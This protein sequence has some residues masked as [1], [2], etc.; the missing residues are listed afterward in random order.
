MADCSV[1]RTAPLTVNGWYRS[2]TVA[3]TAQT[4]GH[5][6][7][8]GSHDRTNCKGLTARGGPSSAS[9]R[10]V[11]TPPVVILSYSRSSQDLIVLRS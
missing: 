2:A 1:G 9:R 10:G 4:A 7:R 11:F 6:I 3:N 8:G 5:S